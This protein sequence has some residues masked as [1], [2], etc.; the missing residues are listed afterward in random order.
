MSYNWPDHLDAAPSKNA[1]RFER[2]EIL[3]GANDGRIYV[4]NRETD[5]QV[6]KIDR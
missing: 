2:K 4:Y 1:I 3:G 5:S 6:D